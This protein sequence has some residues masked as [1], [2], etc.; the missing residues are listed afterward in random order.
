MIVLPG[1]YTETGKI[2]NQARGSKSN[3]SIIGRGMDLR[4]LPV[5]QAPA[6]ATGYLPRSWIL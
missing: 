3:K 5:E 4:M 2:V 1:Y 6:A